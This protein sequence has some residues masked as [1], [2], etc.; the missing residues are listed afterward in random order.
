MVSVCC[1]NCL[2]EE[3][4]RVMALAHAVETLLARGVAIKRHPLDAAVMI[5]GCLL[6][7]VFP[8]TVGR[9]LYWMAWWIF[10]VCWAVGGEGTDLWDRVRRA[11]SLQGRGL[12]SRLPVCAVK[13]GQQI[14]VGLGAKTPGASTPAPAKNLA[15]TGVSRA[16]RSEACGVR[17][18]ARVEWIGQRQ[19]RVDGQMSNLR[20]LLTVEAT[21][22]ARIVGQDHV[23]AAITKALLRRAVDSGSRRPLLS[24]LAAGPT[25][26]GKTETAKALAEILDRPL[27]V[28]DM[29]SFGEQHTVAALIG[30]P[31]GYAGAERCGRLVSDLQRYPHAVVLLDE[32]DKAHSTLMDPFMQVL[33]EGR[34][35]D[36][37]RGEYADFSNAVVIATT[38][39]LQR[40]AIHAWT[41]DSG[42]VRRMLLSAQAGRAGFPGLNSTLRPEL[43]AR[44]DLVLLYKPISPEVADRIAQD[45]ISAFIRRV[46]SRMKIRPEVAVETR[47]VNDL[48]GHCDLQFG[49]RDL[50]RVVQERLGDALVDAYLPWRMRAETPETLEI[51]LQ[52]GHIVATYR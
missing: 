16:I 51:K 7:R 37:S 9:D 10:L 30:A 2:S 5:G 8:L 15:A 50:T 4:N 41:D 13:C 40:E 17:P 14:A 11:L 42:Q 21:L 29:A 27:L 20:R 12:W 3:A 45:Y 35:V 22:K 36:L 46:T 47:L 48:V 6:P 1:Q 39:L 31:P 34:L 44:I 52:D 32:I 25:G 18:E 24:V 28:Y 33:G 38:N 26:V 43:V 49:I 19:T 23:A